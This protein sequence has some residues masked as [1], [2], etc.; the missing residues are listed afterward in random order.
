MNKESGSA[1]RLARV[2]VVTARDDGQPLDAP[3]QWHFYSPAPDRT[4]MEAESGHGYCKFFRSLSA[5]REWGRMFELPWRWRICETSCPLDVWNE[6]SS[7]KGP[8]PA[9]LILAEVFG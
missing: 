7:P 6:L 2:Y 8:P 9:P 4:T 3:D 5:A 1:T